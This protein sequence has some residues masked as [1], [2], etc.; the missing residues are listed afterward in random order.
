MLVRPSAR[1]S[2]SPLQPGWV[3]GVRPPS[4]GTA[5]GRSAERRVWVAW[6]RRHLGPGDGMCPARGKVPPIRRGECR[7]V[8]GL[9][10]AKG[11]RPPR[12]ARRPRARWCPSRPSYAESRWGLFKLDAGVRAALW[13]AAA[14]R[15]PSHSSGPQRS[16]RKFQSHRNA[17]T[18]AANRTF[19][20]QVNTWRRPNHH[21][22]D[23]SPG[24]TRVDPSPRL[25]I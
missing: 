6:P 3:P 2:G 23:R 24:K 9:P 19:I 21:S 16:S 18:A 5:R 22:L 15:V 10:P 1:A 12:S 20:G 11:G 4:G 7:E 17:S 8:P 14:P 25:E 13:R